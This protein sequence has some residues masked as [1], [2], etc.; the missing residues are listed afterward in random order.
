VQLGSIAAVLDARSLLGLER[1]PTG[2]EEQ[3]E[4]FD[5]L[6]REPLLTAL[7]QLP[8]RLIE[9]RSSPG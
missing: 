5:C 6:R 2:I 7:G 4:R 3:Y 8:A 1:K 9:A